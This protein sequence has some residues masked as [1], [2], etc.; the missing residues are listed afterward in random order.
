MIVLRS[1]RLFNVVF[2][3]LFSAL[4]YGYAGH[5]V[6]G[7]QGAGERHGAG[8]RGARHGGTR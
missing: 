7:R 3:V 2:F 5:D 4:R 6:S 8:A 1:Y